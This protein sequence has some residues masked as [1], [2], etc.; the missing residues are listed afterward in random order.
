MAREV[1]G[2]FGG[3]VQTALMRGHRLGF[4]GGTDNHTGWP[5]RLAGV[6]GYGGLTAIQSPRLDGT[7]RSS[8]A[9]TRVAAMPRAARASWPMRRSMDS[10]WGVSLC[11]L[12]TIF[13]QIRV[14]GTVPLDAVQI[15]RW[16]WSSPTSTLSLTRRTWMW[17]GKMT[18][19]DVHCKML[20]TTFDP[21]DRWA[22]CLVE[23]LLG[24]SCGL[25]WL[26]N[27]SILYCKFTSS[28]LGYSS[29][30]RKACRMAAG[31]LVD[32][33]VIALGAAQSGQGIQ[34][35]LALVEEVERR[36]GSAGRCWQI[37]GC[38][39]AE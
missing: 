36:T 15:V 25:A 39:N 27:S 12:Q 1:G 6:P 17:C 35:V 37:I 11:S 5:S 2:G 29:S 26:E 8:P 32:A 22:L 21:P 4:V 10:L 33:V 28:W 14:R 3:S 19:P 18:G 16:G 38:I 7:G 23:S 34:A 30:P 24:R 13:F 31:D 9:S 20:C